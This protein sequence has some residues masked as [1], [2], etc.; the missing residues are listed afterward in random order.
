MLSR[1]VLLVLFLVFLNGRTHGDQIFALNADTASSTATYFGYGLGNT[2]DDTFVYDVRDPTGTLP[3]QLFGSRRSYVP[4]TNSPN[5]TAIARFTLG[6]EYTSVAGDTIVVDAYGS[7]NPTFAVT[8]NDFDVFLYNDAYGGVPVAFQL[9]A[10][11][12]DTSPFHSRIEFMVLAGQTFDRIE[13]RG[14]NSGPYTR[15]FFTLQELRAGVVSVTAP[16]PTSMGIG[17]LVLC[18][19]AA[20]YCRHRRGQQI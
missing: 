17:G 6:S 4:F 13:I 20:A 7:S 9:G 11:I 15:N 1:S 18:A 3:N 19:I 16:E 10:G 8:N 5:Q 12:P 2:L 14:N